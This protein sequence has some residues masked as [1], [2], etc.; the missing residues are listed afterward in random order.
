MYS[1][2]QFKQNKCINSVILCRLPLLYVIIC[3]YNI[4]IQDI[5]LCII[6]INNYN[7]LDNYRSVRVNFLNTTISTY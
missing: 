1:L 6:Q 7:T 2:I 4:V 3:R 5:Q